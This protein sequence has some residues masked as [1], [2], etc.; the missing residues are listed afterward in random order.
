MSGDKN[1]MNINTYYK[2]EYD[3][4]NE[5]IDNALTINDI[6]NSIPYTI[7]NII[8]E[9]KYHLDRLVTFNYYLR[10]CLCNEKCIQ[11]GC[12]EFKL[13]QYCNT[14]IRRYWKI[15]RNICYYYTN[16]KTISCI[17]GMQPQYQW[18][19]YAI[20]WN[21]QTSSFLFTSPR[22]SIL[23]VVRDKFGEVGKLND[24]NLLM[25]L[26]EQ[27]V[28]DTAVEYFHHDIGISSQNQMF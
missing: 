21:E 5:L 19:K 11:T 13:R 10:C 26:M 27:L 24:A 28:D 7:L 14:C 20:I 22:K 25:K 4:L 17:N 8:L 12:I 2:S 18:L 9:Y 23:F 15:K 16:F 6:L 1:N 3:M